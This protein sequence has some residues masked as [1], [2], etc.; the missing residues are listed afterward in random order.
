MTTVWLAGLTVGLLLLALWMIQVGRRTVEGNTAEEALATVM[1]EFDQENKELLRSITQLKRAHDIEMTGMKAELASVLEKIHMLQGQQEELIQ[2]LANQPAHV[3]GQA[4]RL[5]P[6]A[7]PMLYLKEDYREVP[8]L[9]EEGMSPHEIARKLGI[10]DGEVA[11]V[12]Q[13]LKKQGF[14]S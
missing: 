10:G 7:Q 8:A 9:Y 11:M 4:D 2:K 13:M 1:Q 5:M 14:F 3:T 6:S 12:I